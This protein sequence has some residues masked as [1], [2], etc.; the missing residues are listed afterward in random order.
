M[1]AAR[2]AG[3]FSMCIQNRGKYF[4]KPITYEIMLTE[5]FIAVNGKVKR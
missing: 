4:L 3:V 2:L 1:Y 5:N